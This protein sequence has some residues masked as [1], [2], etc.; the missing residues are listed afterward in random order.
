T[1]FLCITSTA[2]ERV[3][4]SFPTRRSSDLL[5]ARL[6]PAH[7]ERVV[8]ALQRNGHVVG[9]MGDGINDASALRAADVG[10]SVDNAVDIAKESADLILLE[11]DL[12]VLEP[13]LFEGRRVFGNIV[14]DI[15]ME[16]G[17]NFGNMFSVL[18]ASA[19]LTFLPLLPIQL[20]TQHLLYAFSQLATP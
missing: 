19:F 12:L 17:T 10:V 11:K 8:R 5:F 2:D 15:K 9:F 20:L 7:K 18:G 3:Q 14:K 6:S 4:P 13:G 16:T 1:S